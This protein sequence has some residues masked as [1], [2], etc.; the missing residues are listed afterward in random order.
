[1]GSSLLSTIT[2]C[3]G[4]QLLAA[5]SIGLLVGALLAE[6]AIFI[7][8]WRA[9]PA[10]TFYSLHKEYGPRLY[11][12]F[13]PLTVVPSFLSLAAVVLSIMETDAGRWPTL[14]AFILFMCVLATYAGYFKRANARLAAATLSAPELSLEL[15]RWESW[16]WV[17]VVLGVFSFAAALL[18]VGMHV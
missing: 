10:E 17:R 11:R 7:P 18:G 6:G 4:L 16:H 2:F 13:A 14:A 5:G 1:M 8:Y 12:F 9:L 15:A 3:D